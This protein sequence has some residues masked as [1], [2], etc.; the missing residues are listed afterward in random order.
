MW[1]TF[2]RAG[3]AY[4]LYTELT[5]KISFRFT[6][7][8]IIMRPSVSCYGLTVQRDC[9]ALMAASAKRDRRFG[10]IGDS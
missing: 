1:Y 6:E 3:G 5:A 10:P 2:K 9:N 7:L 4:S 8:Y